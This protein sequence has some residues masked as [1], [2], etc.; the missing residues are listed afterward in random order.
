[1]FLRK[2]FKILRGK[3]SA[4]QIAS[5]CLLASWIAF[6]PGI[7]Q[8]PGL[9]FLFLSLLVILN[10][11]LF[12][13][14]LVGI[15]AQL[16]SLILLPLTFQLGQILIDGPTSGLW[17]TL[18]NAPVLAWFGFENY[19]ASGGLLF[20]TLFGAA[21]AILV[22]RAVFG[23]RNKM[24]A[25]ENDSEAFNK[26]TSNLAVKG[27][28]FILIGGIKGKKSYEELTK[29]KMGNPFRILGVI[30]LAG[31]T[32]LVVIGIMILDTT[33]ITNQVRDRLEEANG[34]TVDLESLE[35]IAE[36]GRVVITG[37]AITNPN[38]LETNLFEATTITADVSSRSLLQK[39]VALDELTITGGRVG[40]TR[41]LPGQLT[42][43]KP[44]VEKEPPKTDDPETKGL[45]DY[46]E[47][48]DVWKERLSQ[49]KK[50]LD[51]I[52]P[53]SEEG[54]REDES[55][56]VDKGPS[57]QEQLQAQADLLGYA[58]VRATH[59][60]TESPSFVIGLLQ[61]GGV[62]VAQMPEETFSFSGVQLSS[63]P[64]LN[65]E[66]AEL[67]LQTES[68]QLGLTW[69]LPVNS[70]GKLAL[71]LRDIP[72]SLIQEYITAAR[73]VPMEGGTVTI[74]VDG[75]FAPS[76]L[77]M[78]VEVT[79]RDTTISGFEADEI[80]VPITITGSMTNP[81]V[82]VSD[83]ALQDVI[84]SAAQQALENKAKEEGKKFLEDQLGEGAGSLIDGI[85]GGSKKKSGEDP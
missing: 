22:V 7:G 54:E 70:Q 82:K 20:G 24:A 75:P 49:A 42:R 52:N 19:V 14:A 21:A 40:S 16:A 85:F 83:G 37:L 9:F 69:T 77:D 59:R 12:I 68:D 78:P 60:I 31:S 65:P 30:L 64:W 34:A 51:Q 10:A 56:R 76:N 41:Q 74:Q 15:V 2:L 13:A 57:L 27:L 43:P 81:G 62:K 5:A 35:L 23:F 11:N 18:I 3:V 36:E 84:A 44:K 1:M 55:E 33:I 32:V 17:T 46:L 71:H 29:A 61:A 39:K 79:I 72:L 67:K 80:L 28:A 45:D 73:Q 4:F 6:L 50:W 48:A 25:L 63:Q 66:P 53:P 58:N 26:W 38:Q 47:D 8:A